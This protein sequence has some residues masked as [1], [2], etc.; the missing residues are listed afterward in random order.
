MSEISFEKSA[1]EDAL[2]KLN[3]KEREIRR[4]VEDITTRTPVSTKMPLSPISTANGVPTVVNGD[5][6]KKGKKRKA[7]V[8]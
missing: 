4:R 3:A 2:A 8:A 1:N 6:N 7:Q 5:L